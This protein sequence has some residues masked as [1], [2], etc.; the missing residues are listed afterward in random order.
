[1]SSAVPVTWTTIRYHGIAGTVKPGIELRPNVPSVLEEIRTLPMGTAFSQPYWLREKGTPGMFRVDDPNLIGL[2]EEPPA[3][4]IE[5]VFTVGGQTLVVA[6]EVVQVTTDPAKGEIRRRVDVMP[7]V[8]LSFSSPVALFAPGSERKIEVDVVSS[9]SGASGAVQLAA[10]AGW[11]ATPTTQ[12]FHLAG[13]GDHAQLTFT[14]SAPQSPTIGSIAATVRIDGVIYGNG[15]IEITYPHIPPQLLQPT[16]LLKAVALDLSIRGKSIGYLP[17]AGDSVAAS[18]EQM[19]YQVTQLNDTDLTA[20]NLKQFDAVVI[21]VR[22]F[23]TRKE[24]AAHL[25]GLFAYVEAGGTVVEQ[26]NTPG[27]LQTPQLG[28]YDLKLNRDLPHYRVIDEKG[29]VTLL[30]PCHPEFTTPNTIVPGDFDGGVQERGL[31]FASEW[32]TAHWESLLSCSDVGKA[33]L[34]GGLLV[35]HYGKG[36][37]VYHG[38]FVLPSAARRGSRGLPAFRQSGFSREMNPPPDDE[39]TGLPGLRTWRQESICSSSLSSPP[40]SA[41]PHDADPDVSVNAVDYVI[42]PWS[43]DRDRRLR[44][45]AHA[46]GS[47]TSTPISRAPGRRAGSRSVSR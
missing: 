47:G 35:A 24:L 42:L 19:G 8:S 17:G 18:L 39:I 33:P 32:D 20:D 46:G 34:K 15:R 36:L 9:R 44:H 16:A 38:L 43:I 22:A 29:P 7:P 13:V 14:V 27:G 1:M 10:P 37:F 28:N 25:P 11:K 21:G 31:D 41:P 45:L 23:N 40:G 12:D 3:V 26:Y 5:N 4:R 2:P 6:E 30:D